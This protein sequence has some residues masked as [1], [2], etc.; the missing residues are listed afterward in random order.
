M[1]VAIL[2]L[3]VLVGISVLGCT[4][5]S[6]LP[7][8]DSPA[9]TPPVGGETN[10]EINGGVVLPPDALPEEIT[11]ISPGKVNVANFY[12]GAR[13]EYPI[14]IHNGSDYSCTFEVSYRYPDHV[15]DDYVKPSFAV[16]DWVIVADMSPVLMPGETKEI[17]VILEM[18]SGAAVF[19]QEWEFWISVIDVTQA[20][21]VRTELCCR[22][23]ISMRS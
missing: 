15:G 23:L 4:T 14:T 2:A 17:L 19:A 5:P 13:A 11:W 6:Y 9:S 1:K 3:I 18:P 7:T 20:G 12:P 21:M 8:T 10:H 22:W 16:Q